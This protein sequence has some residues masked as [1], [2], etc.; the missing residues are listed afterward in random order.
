MRI[1]FDPQGALGGSRYRGIGR[2]TRSFL[3]E[4]A[5]LGEKHEIFI[6]LNTMLP[7]AI[8]Q[9]RYELRDLIPSE[10]FITWSAESPV[11]GMFMENWDRR[12]F[13]R[14]VWEEAVNALEPD[15]LIVSSL[16]EGAEDNAVSAIP[17]GRDYLVATIC[18]DL[19][20]LLYRQHYLLDPG[21]EAYY[22]SPLLR[23][24]FSFCATL[25]SG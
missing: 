9:L 15:L 25:P 12:A 14:E 20:P 11:G 7:E 4:F 6:L 22:R 16:F 13:A 2:Y 5:R 10:N 23:R 8:D 21:M 17:V 19:I 18:Y 1:V 24:P 3:R